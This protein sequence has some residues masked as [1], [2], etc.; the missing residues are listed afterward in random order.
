[1][2]ALSGYFLP[3]LNQTEVEVLPH[4]KSCKKRLKTSLERRERNRANRAMMRS[5]LKK[6]RTESTAEERQT[7]LSEMYSLLDVQ[8]RKGIIPRSRAARLKSRL[9]AAAV[10]AA[11]K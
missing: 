9:A 7:K 11:Q 6:Y 3:S 4:H 1:M 10:A 5:V 2:R 8:A